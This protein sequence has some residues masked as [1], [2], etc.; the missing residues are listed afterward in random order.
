[1][2]KYF[3]GANYGWSFWKIKADQILIGKRVGNSI[4]VHISTLNDLSISLQ[5]CIADA[6]EIAAPLAFAPNVFRVDEKKKQVSLLFYS[7]FDV[8]PF[9]RLVESIFVD[10]SLDRAKRRSYRLSENP[11]ILHRKELLLSKKHPSYLELAA[12]T[13]KLEDLGLFDKPHVIGHSI[14]W[15]ARLT[16]A[17][18]FVNNDGKLEFRGELQE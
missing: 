3:A 11:P 8:D 5:A 7:N 10:L 13:A 18:I 1:M 6:K 15:N 14:E 4:Y 12:L 9:P 17:G 2:D 16:K